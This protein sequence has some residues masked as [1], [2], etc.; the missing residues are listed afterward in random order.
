MSLKTKKSKHEICTMVLKFDKEKLYVY[1]L[2]NGTFLYF[3]TKQFPINSLPQNI[4]NQL[5]LIL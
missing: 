1:E 4:K 5:S 2:S 3:E